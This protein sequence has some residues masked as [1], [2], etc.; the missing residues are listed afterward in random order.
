VAEDIVIKLT[1]GR[2]R[3]C[4][5]RGAVTSASAYFRTI[6]TKINSYKLF[7]CLSHS[8]EIQKMLLIILML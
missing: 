5:S 7:Q 1:F 4:L 6:L 2:R 3:V 8:S